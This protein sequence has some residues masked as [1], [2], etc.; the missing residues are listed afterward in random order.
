MDTGIVKG[1]KNNYNYNHRS[2][3]IVTKFTET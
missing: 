2:V 3:T 1:K